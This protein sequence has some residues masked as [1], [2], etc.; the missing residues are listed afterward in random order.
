ME[1]LRNWGLLTGGTK[2]PIFCPDNFSREV[3]CLPGV[4]L[5]DIRKILPQLIKPE[6]YYSF[7]DI[8][9]GTRNAA[10]RKL[11]NIKKMH[12]GKML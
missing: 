12:L 7:I 11:K 5:R 1:S 8:Q 2:A 6:D 10:M 3:C 4:C 9:A